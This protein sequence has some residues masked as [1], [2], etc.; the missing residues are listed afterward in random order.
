MTDF[1][2]LRASLLQGIRL[3]KQGSYQRRAPAPEA[4]PILISAR[5][6]LRDFIKLFD[7]NAEAWR[8]LSQAEECLLNYPAAIECLQQAMTLASRKDRNDLKRLAS[9]NA[10]AQNWNAL[11]LTPSQLQELGLYL[12]QHCVS[13]TS[14]DRSMPLTNRWLS[15]IHHPEGDKVIS[16]LH[17]M[18][19]FTDFQVLNVVMG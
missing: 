1:N 3:S 11:A 8:A 6:G 7:D 12:R 19:A 16:A 13:A 5:D 14:A 2:T 18:G 17:N 9:L 15:L 4:V 10:A